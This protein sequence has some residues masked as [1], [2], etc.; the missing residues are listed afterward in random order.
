MGCLFI[1][2]A[3]I[4]EKPFRVPGK[5]NG[6][7]LF[8]EIILQNQIINLLRLWDQSLILLTFLHTNINK[9]PVR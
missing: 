6:L 4:P 7:G 3:N 5:R 8:Y 2:N 1:V 9:G